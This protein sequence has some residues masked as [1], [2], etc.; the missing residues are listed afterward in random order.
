MDCAV[1]AVRRLGPVLEVRHPPLPAE[2]KVSAVQLLL[3]SNLR[4]RQVS[5][6]FWRAGRIDLVPVAGQ[7]RT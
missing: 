7:C 4:S 6:S 5:E 1:I 2:S 3:A